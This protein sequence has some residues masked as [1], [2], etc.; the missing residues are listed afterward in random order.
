MHT[1]LIHYGP[2]PLHVLA[3]NDKHIASIQIQVSFERL[4]ST[5]RVDKCYR[6]CFLNCNGIS[7]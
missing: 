6:A 3:S 1:D 5:F 7:A 2:L 4:F